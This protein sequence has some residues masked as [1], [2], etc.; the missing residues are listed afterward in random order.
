MVKKYR[1]KDEYFDIPFESK[2][3]EEIMKSQEERE[4]LDDLRGITFLFINGGLESK[5]TQ[6]K[7]TEYTKKF[8]SIPEELQE[9]LD[10]R[11]VE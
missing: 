1:K 7:I 3:Q 8:G 6:E 4:R 10:A 11:P 5:I 9:L 2:T